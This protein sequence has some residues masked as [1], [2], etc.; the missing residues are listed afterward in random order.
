MFLPTIEE[1]IFRISGARWAEAISKTPV[2]KY[3]IKKYRKYA[4]Y[5]M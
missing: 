1:L 4:R 2:V 3:P 5:P